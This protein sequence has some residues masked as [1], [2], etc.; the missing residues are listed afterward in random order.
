M[1]C[2]ASQPSCSTRAARGSSACRATCTMPESRQARSTTIHSGDC[3]PICASRS[4]RPRPD[5]SKC[6][7]RSTAAAI[8]TPHESS[9]V[10]AYASGIRPGCGPARPVGSTMAG[11]SNASAHRMR[12]SS[13]SDPA[14]GP[15]PTVAGSARPVVASVGGMRVVA[16]LAVMIPPARR[17]GRCP[18]QG[19]CTS[20]PGR[21]G[22]P[23]PA[24]H[25]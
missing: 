24:W 8:N 22:L 16:A 20:W 21:A 23:I 19:R 7:A 4:P 15:P 12:R 14:T 18:G 25:G 2:G 17:A 1:P 10:V 9:R 6:A 11:R 13:T 3:G 5:R